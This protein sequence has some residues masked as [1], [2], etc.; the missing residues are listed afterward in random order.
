MAAGVWNSNRRR[1]PRAVVAT[2]APRR[3]RLVRSCRI[4][5]GAP[6]PRRAARPR[7][8]PG[9]PRLYFRWH[10]CGRLA[11]VRNDCA[12]VLLWIAAVAGCALW[13][14]GLAIHMGTDGADD[15]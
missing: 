7:A 8:D 5:A 14:T 1:M 12:A 10:L 15:L 3:H 4:R 6:R 9:E 11:S 2:H 13:R